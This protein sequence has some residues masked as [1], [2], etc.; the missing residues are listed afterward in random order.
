MAV[1]LFCDASQD[2]WGAVCAQLPESELSKPRE[3]QNH[4]LLAFLSGRFV[5]AQSRWPTI[6]KEAYAIVESVKRLEYLLLRPKGFHLFTDHRN[7][8]Y[9]FDPYATDTGMQRYQADKLQRWAMTLTAYR[10]VVEHV[11]GDEN[12]WADILSRWSGFAEDE[13]HQMSR[14]SALGLVSTLSPLTTQDFQWPS[15]TEISALQQPAERSEEVQWEDARQCFVILGDK[16]W[17]PPTAVDLMEQICVVGHAGSSGHRDQKATL[18]S[19]KA[20]CWWET[21][22]KD[23]QTFVSRCIHCLSTRG[24]T[25]PRPFGPA[26][27]ATKPNEVL[28]FDYLSMPEDEDTQNKYILVIKDDFSGFVE[29]IPG[30]AADAETSTTPVSAIFKCDAKIE[31]LAEDE[32]RL[33]QEQHFKELANALDAL[34]REVAMSSSKRRQQARDRRAMNAQQA[35]FGSGDY[36]LAAS[37]IEYPNKLAIKWQGP[38]RIINCLSD[39]IFEVQDLHAPF[40][41]HTHHASRLRF[42]AESHRE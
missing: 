27:H 28:H 13:K 35:R 33:M 39:W 38:K 6:E 25:E 9:I 8:V 30:K 16:I 15:L 4:R 3:E 20:W 23:V 18:E 17:I 11:K 5:N 24:G 1:S 21:L 12:V 40:T 26:L 41:I 29:L 19:I 34:H 10:Y 42:Y 2:F 7:L 32:L 37:V 22:A 31:S 36:V 14:I